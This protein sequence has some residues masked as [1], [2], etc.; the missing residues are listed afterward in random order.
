MLIPIGMHTILQIMPLHF[1]YV[2]FKFFIRYIH[3]YVQI[4][5]KN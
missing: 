5:N 3:I 2:N 4:Y 1:S